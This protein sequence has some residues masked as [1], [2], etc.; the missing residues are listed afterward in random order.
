MGF[1]LNGLNCI[2]NPEKVWESLS[3]CNYR[4]VRI[5]HCL[6][7]SLC[8]LVSVL[9]TTTTTHL[10]SLSVQNTLFICIFWANFHPNFYCY[11]S[12]QQQGKRSH[13]HKSNKKEHYTILTSFL[14]PC[15]FLPWE[16]CQKMLITTDAW[17]QNVTFED[18][19]WSRMKLW[20][21]KM[22]N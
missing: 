11:Y 17:S 5:W 16:I 6:Q 18:D 14:F 21:R 4:I 9:G 22:K 8:A 20:E 7:L 15:N 2:W 12:L 19:I 10:F 3:E 1:E 13:I